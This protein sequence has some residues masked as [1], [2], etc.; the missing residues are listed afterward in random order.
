M[1]TRIS[2]Y[3]DVEA[4]RRVRLDID[5]AVL[6]A[7][8]R[9]LSVSFADRACVPFLGAGISHPPPSSLPLAD[10][11]VSALLDV[12]WMSIEGFASRG[13]FDR[14]GQSDAES[15]LKNARL[16]RI[17]H[18]FQRTH[19]PKSVGEFLAVL[20]GR[21]WNDNHAAIAAI[22]SKGL[23]ESCV[24]LNFDLLLEEAIMDHGGASRTLCPLSGDKSFEMSAKSKSPPVKILKP[25]GSFAPPESGIS[26]FA[27]LSPTI[28]EIGNQ[29][30]ARNGASFERHL[31][32]GSSVVVAG[33][34][35]NDWDIFPLLKPLMPRF[36]HLYWVL[37]RP[38]PSFASVDRWLRD[39]AKKVTVLDGDPRLLWSRIC[40]RL[41]IVPSQTRSSNRLEPPLTAHTSQF[42][43]SSDARAA[44]AVAFSLLL[45]DR[46]EFHHA[47]V[48][49]LLVKPH[50]QANSRLLAMVHRTAAQSCH[51]R[52]DLTH[53]LRHMEKVTSIHAYEPEN[54]DRAEALIWAGY[55]H[56]CLLKRPSLR[57]LVLPLAF[58][59]HRRGYGMM[60]EGL[61]LSR[62]LGPT[63]RQKLRAMVRYYQGDLI[64]AWASLSLLLGSWISSL[65][66]PLFRRA[67]RWYERAKR[68]DPTT[69]NWEY[70]WFRILEAHFFA[71]GS[72]PSRSKLMSKIE[73]IGASY[74]M[75]QNHVQRGNSLAYRALLGSTLGMQTEEM[76]RLLDQ[77]EKMWNASSSFVPSG[78]LRVISFRRV[79]GL[80]GLTAT[81]R[82]LW[83]LH[84]LLRAVAVE[85][86]NQAARRS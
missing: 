83:R 65:A 45:Q 2:R 18:A 9:E 61:R 67:C 38:E 79:L 13:R 6:E 43:D 49:W 55:E 84:K 78:L 73:E 48:D 30:D 59:T 63:K 12:L 42:V 26:L 39:H 86:V 71:D 31:R 19:D 35:D 21:P 10:T 25:H 27:L 70:Y 50:I 53:A 82:D 69:M 54:D 85:R 22:A 60:L 37:F 28:A 68:I 16:E 75:L 51:T 47:L 24:T 58:R 15:M 23:L 66:R 11:L 81:V 4:Y 74:D 17:L 41:G 29:P 3:D 33:Y 77:A 46:G 34:S 32:S 44:T 62:R 1:T 5:S 56:Y 36:N 7:V 80:R 8:V 64:H 52:R 20:I 14:P 72:P 57:W 40:A 76:R